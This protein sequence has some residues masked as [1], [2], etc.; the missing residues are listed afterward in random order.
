MTNINFLHK[1]NQKL[2]EIDIVNSDEKLC[3]LFN[4]D[5][6]LEL[7]KYENIMDRYNKSGFN[8]TFDDY[9]NFRKHWQEFNDSVARDR[10]KH[11]NNQK[12]FKKFY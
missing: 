6:I 1:I 9:L 7:R 3:D 5:E 12:Y 8:F 2:K 11:D 10:K 4:Q